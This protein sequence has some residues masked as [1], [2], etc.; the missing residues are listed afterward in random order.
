[1]VL[2][3]DGE[4]VEPLREEFAPWSFDE[5]ATGAQRADQRDRLAGLRARGY[6]IGEGCTVSR[7]AAVHPDTFELGDRSYVAAHA[8]VSGDVV[9]GADCSVNASAVVR[10][11]VR[12]G[13]AVRIGGH[14]SL[15]GFDHGFADTG[16]EMFRQPLTCAGIVVG[17]DVW[18]GSHVVVVDGVRIGSHAVIGAGS[19]V[20]RDVPDWAVVVGNPARVVR[21]RRDP[22]LSA[23]PVSAP[24]QALDD[25]LRTFAER[26]RRDLPQI[27]ADSWHDG[28]YRNGPDEGATV[29]AHTDAVELSI[30]LRAAAPPQLRPAEHVARLQRAQDPASGLVAELV[31]GRWPLLDGGSADPDG[32][33]TATDGALPDDA[34]AYHVLC[35]GYALDLLGAAFRHPVRAVTALDPGALT[36]ALD[37]LPWHTNAWG[38]G[39]TVDTVGTALTWALR[40]GDRCP[41]GQLEAVVGWL[42]THRDPA[43]GLW[44]SSSDGLLD[45]VN[46]AYRAVRGTLAQWGVR[47]GGDRTLVGTVLRR[48][49]DV[50]DAPGTTACDALDVVH[51]LWW[52][53]REDV[54]AP[55]SRQTE[56]EAVARGVVETTLRA[57]VPGRGI[58]FGPGEGPSLKGTEMWLATAWYAADLLGEAAALGY[59]PRGIHRPEPVL[60]GEGHPFGVRSHR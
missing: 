51:L 6:V 31:D 57:W 19:V 20:T 59:R 1:M 35:V 23:P 43:T 52:A 33:A 49:E 46:G 12:T 32:L 27:L 60:G 15:L 34:R 21:D 24:A 17:D 58:A 14:T 4:P 10:G 3:R 47:I 26:A 11:R 5:S 56:V 36:R 30:L 53:A 55:R 44:G 50:G 22:R 7:L 13:R 29:R 54:E 40:A 37:A 42:A 16:T 18:I 9:I 45:P 48:A 39:A 41:P 38:A 2:S 8:H 28:A 25:R